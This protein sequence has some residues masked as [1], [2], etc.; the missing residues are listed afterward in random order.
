MKKLI[1]STAILFAVG[2]TVN[3]Q[4]APMKE[5]KVKKE[6]KAELKDHLCT[7]AC[8]KAGKCVMAHGEKGHKC[9]KECKKTA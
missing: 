9:S 7:D 2:F 1:F 5:K 8:H 4:T 3:A 6:K